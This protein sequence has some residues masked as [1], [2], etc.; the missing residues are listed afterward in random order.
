MLNRC[1][2]FFQVT[3]SLRNDTGQQYACTLRNGRKLRSIYNRQTDG[4]RKS[5]KGLPRAGGREHGELL[6]NQYRI[7]VQEEENVLEIAVL[8][9]QHSECI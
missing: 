6:F 4:D 3:L 2:L 5:N 1:K 8:D 7:S 9:T